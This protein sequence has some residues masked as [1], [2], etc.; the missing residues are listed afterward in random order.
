MTPDD[1][2][3]LLIRHRI[4][5][6]QEQQYEAW[7][8][9][10]IAIAKGYPGHLGID[11]VRDRKDGLHLF[12]SILRFASTAQLQ[13]WLD[14]AERRQLVEEVSPLLADGDQLEINPE[15]EFWFTPAPAD[16]PQP[17]RWK[18]ACV[19]FLV[20]L[21]LALLVPLLWQPLFRLWPWLGGYVPSN[22]VITL[23]IVML[24]VY[25]FMPP[26]TRFF[27]GWLNQR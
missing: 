22:V 2:V 18:Q 23:S 3:T 1:V 20:I 25:L 7:L 17:P 5:Q 16:M 6:G 24:V 11:V 21:P 27:A 4:K 10:I 8:R 12:T 14:S 19:T 9:R 26:V 13:A 15:R